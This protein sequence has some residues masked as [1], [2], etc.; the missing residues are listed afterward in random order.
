MSHQ[1][2][3]SLGLNRGQALANGRDLRANSR[4]QVMRL[5]LA[6]DS[7]TDGFD[8][9]VDLFKRAVADEQ[10]RIAHRF[11]R[12][13]LADV[14]RQSKSNHQRGTSGDYRFEIW[15]QERTD[16]GQTPHL[17]RVVAVI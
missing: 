14:G 16:T 8:T 5:G 11:E 13:Y 15:R 4:H 17:W 6:A 2:Q 3:G 12:A 10:H 1:H 9:V 7:R